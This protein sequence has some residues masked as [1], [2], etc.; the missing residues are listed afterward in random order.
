MHPQA[1][2]AGDEALTD[3]LADALAGTESLDHV[4][5]ADHV[6]RFDTVHT[7]LNDALSRID[8]D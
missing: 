4:P 2:T 6:A 8:T 7:A 5:L 3:A 1:P